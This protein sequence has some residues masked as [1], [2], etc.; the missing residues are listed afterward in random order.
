MA[1]DFARKFCARSSAR[2]AYLPVDVVQLDDGRICNTE[3]V[4]PARRRPRN[5]GSRTW[6]ARRE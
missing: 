5:W 1:R 4:P 6:A 2:V 3:P